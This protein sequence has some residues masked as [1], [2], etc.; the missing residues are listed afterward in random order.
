MLG[1]SQ[2]SS[3]SWERGCYPPK[4]SFPFSSGGRDTWLSIDTYQW[5]HIKADAGFQAPSVPTHNYFLYTSK[6][7]CYP[8]G[9]SHL[10]SQFSSYSLSAFHCNS[11]YSLSCLLHYPC[12]TCSPLAQIALV[13]SSQLLFLSSLNSFK[14]SGYF[15]SLIHNKSLFPQP[16]S[17]HFRSCL[18]APPHVYYGRTKWRQKDTSEMKEEKRLGERLGQEVL[19]AGVWVIREGR[20][21]T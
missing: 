6:P 14:C 15:L 18:T 9:T 20:E 11:H 21:H 17:S 12:P 7:P 3:G 1:K 4:E 13:M 5:L 16:R 19:E 2:H 8:P 10:R